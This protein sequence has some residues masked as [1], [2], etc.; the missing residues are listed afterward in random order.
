VTALAPGSVSMRLYPHN[1]LDDPVAVVEEQRV[2]ARLAA[3]SGFAGVMT[4]EHHGGFAGYAPNPLQAA[5]WLLDAMP[6]GWC[7]PCPLL[8]P[9]RPVALVAEEVAWLAARFPGRVAV[10]V[11]PGALPLDFEAMG[12]PFDEK[13]ERFRADL[14]RLVAMLR[15]EDL[16]PLAGD[17]ALS[18]CRDRP[19]PVIS[20]ALSPGA[21]RRAAAAGAGIVYDGASAL[22]R[23]RVLSDAYDQAGGRGPKVLIRRVWLGAPPREAFDRQAEVYRSYSPAAAQEHWRGHGFLTHDDGASL[24]AELAAALDDAGADTLNLRVHV[25]G[26]T[27]EQARDQIARLGTEVLPHLTGTD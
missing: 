9:L 5:G 27:P 26:V 13:V 10:G 17:L 2:Q 16:G 8:L 12:V 25:P 19:V 24:A 20:T 21:V 7:A 23:L 22:D 18:A 4:S 11:A 6:S 15:G 14:P 1:E 3:E